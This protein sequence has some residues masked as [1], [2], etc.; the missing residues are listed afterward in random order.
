MPV[1]PVINSKNSFASTIVARN[2][3][4]MPQ[5]THNSAKHNRQRR[6]C[7]RH[8]RVHQY[9][10]VE[11]KG[12]YQLVPSSRKA[13]ANHGNKN[14]KAFLGLHEDGCVSR[15]AVASRTTRAI[16]SKPESRRNTWSTAQ[17]MLTAANQTM[18]TR[19][20]TPPKPAQHTTCTP[21]AAPRH[22]TGTARHDVVLLLLF[23]LLLFLFLFLTLSTATC[24]EPQP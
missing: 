21:Q 24:S 2:L 3:F 17:V 14:T 11:L 15:S 22:R 4:F 23:L 9:H 18:L 8:C 13:Q 10:P 1:T 5:T 20:Y 16:D 12:Q 7:P 19:A 6:Q